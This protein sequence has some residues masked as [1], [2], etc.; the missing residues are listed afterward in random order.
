MKTQTKILNLL[1]ITCIVTSSALADPEFIGLGDLDGSNFQSYANGVSADG[2]VVVGQSYSSNGPEAFGWTQAGDMVGI[3]DLEGGDFESSANGVSA[4]GSVIV[5]QSNSSNGD[6]AF[7]WTEAGKMV[8]LGD[9]EGGIFESWAQGV[10]AD[11]SVV[12]GYGYSTA[13]GEEKEAFRWTEASGM[14]GLGD[15]EGGKFHSDAKGVSADGSVVVGYSNSTQGGEAFRWTEAGMI[16]L[17]DL[18]GGGFYSNANAVS[19]DGSVVVGQSKSGNGL[20]AF[21][22]TEAGMVGIGDLEGGTFQSEA[23][24]VSADGSVVVGQGN[25]AI[26]GEAFRWTE[27]DEMQTISDWLAESGVTVEDG[28]TLKVATGVSDDGTVVVGNGISSRGKEAWLARGGSGVISIE[29]FTQT[30]GTTASISQTTLTLPSTILNG[31][32]HHVLLTQDFVDQDQMAWLNGDFADHDRRDAEIMLGEVGYAHDFKPGLRGG[33]GIGYGDLDQDLSYNG[34]QELDGQYIMAEIDWQIPDTSVILSLTGIYG[35]WQTDIDRGYTNAGT[36]D[37]S[38]G[39]TDV[40]TMTG[41]IRADW[42]DAFQLLGFSFTPRAAY[43]ITEIDTD[44][45]TE[46]GGGFPAK[47]DSMSHTAQEFR[48]GL[49]GEKALNKKTTIRGIFE[50]VYRFD[51]DNDDFSGE[52]IDAFQFSIAGADNEQ[53]WVRVGAEASHRIR[54]NMLLSATVFTASEGE[55][56]KFSGALN[57]QYLF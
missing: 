23:K 55:D 48:V 56:A 17:G 54:E 32:H 30:F 1:T 53:E 57:F 50:A 15:L 39:D 20:E 19:A 43:S 27:A 25:S 5:G 47:F 38:S 49:T 26:G 24:S 40:T 10:S 13:S 4:D 36:L 7:R 14:V 9:L 42:V 52:V 31:A 11:G 37:Q 29:E 18:E 6:E 41:R 21:R 3:G 8:G 22:W 34:K 28:F 2:S 16:G 51:E 46:T 33:L 45:Y 35:D 12:V 44:S